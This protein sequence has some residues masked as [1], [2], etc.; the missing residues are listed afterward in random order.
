MR[1]NRVDLPALVYYRERVDW[2]PQYGDYVV[3]SRWFSAWHGI[4]VDYDG[5]DE[6]QIIWG[7]VPYLLFTMD[8]EQQQRETKTISLKKILN[9]KNGEYAIQQ[10]D[11]KASRCIWY[12]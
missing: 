2:I 9:S 3:W 10:F 7:G 5:E 12:I 11:Q 4:I 6:M 1:P 8:Q